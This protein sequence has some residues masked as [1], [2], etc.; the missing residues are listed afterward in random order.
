MH[1]R[2]SFFWS[3]F[4]VIR[5]QW[6]NISGIT[7][8]TT[9]NIDLKFAFEMLHVT[10]LCTPTWIKT[11]LFHF[12]CSL[13][14]FLSICFFLIRR[15]SFEQTNS[16]TRVKNKSFIGFKSKECYLVN[17]C[18]SCLCVQTKK[19]KRKNHSKIYSIYL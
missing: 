1:H 8:T 19:W 14:L 15:K 16:R 9:D 17:W 10:K 6:L 7:T 3:S 13:S 11:K 4:D 5:I 18:H 2:N 12:G